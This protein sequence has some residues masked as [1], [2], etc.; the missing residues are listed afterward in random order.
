[1]AKQRVFWFCWVHFSFPSSWS[2]LPRSRLIFDLLR[3]TKNWSFPPLLI[4]LFFENFLQPNK[5]R[6]FS[7]HFIGSAFSWP[8][9][10]LK[11]QL[12]KIQ[13]SSFFTE[14]SFRLC[15]KYNICNKM[16]IHRCGNKISKFLNHWISVKLL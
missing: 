10:D 12:I 11:Q 9:W 8:G 16:K 4:C 6:F 3:S 15:K 13:V 5:D 1:M 14:K 7:W 2:A